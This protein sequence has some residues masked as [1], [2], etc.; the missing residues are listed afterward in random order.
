MKEE[1]TK[2]YLDGTATHEEEGLL[3][4]LLLEEPS[5]TPQE[6]ALKAMLRLRPARME[7][8][9]EWMQEDESALFDSMVPPQRHG[10]KRLRW[11]LPAAA[12]ALVAVV[13]MVC[14]PDGGE[15][16]VTYIYGNKVES[17]ALAMEM[18][19]QTMDELLDRPAMEDEMGQLLGR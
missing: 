6:R 16:A 4:D 2:K 18:M 14:R 13:W 12:A 1:L 9:E 11:L 15:S 7:A 19:E 17:E 10:V 8:R 5:P 3:R